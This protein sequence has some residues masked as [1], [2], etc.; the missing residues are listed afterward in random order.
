MDKKDD[1]T[2]TLERIFIFVTSLVVILICVLIYVTTKTRYSQ[3]RFKLL[4]NSGGRKEVD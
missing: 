1:N 2:K 3:N 4:D